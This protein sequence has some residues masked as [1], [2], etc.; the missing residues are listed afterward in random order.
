[1]AAAASS[2]QD[3]IKKSFSINRDNKT[4]SMAN[5]GSDKR[6]FFWQIVLRVLAIVFGASAIGVIVTSDQTVLIYGIEFDAKYTYS[7]A[8]KF[9]VGADA[10]ICACAILSLITVISW[11]PPRSDHKYHFAIF[12]HDLVMMVLEISGC[13]AASAIGWIALYGQNDVGW[14]TVCD[15]AAKFCIQVLISLIFSFLAFFVFLILTVMSTYKLKQDLELKHHEMLLKD[16]GWA[17]NGT[18]PP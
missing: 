10:V 3:D 15:H 18:L 4:L 7:A 16:G 9:L 2:D 14:V 6:L 17:L 11:G 1:M 12:F 5:S 13:A 8:F